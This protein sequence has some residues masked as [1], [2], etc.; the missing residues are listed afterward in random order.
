MQGAR[1]T[2]AVVVAKGP[3]ARDR[4]LNVI[5]GYL[6]G[7][8]KYIPAWETRLGR[9]PQV[10]DYLQKLAA[11]FSVAYRFRDMGRKGI[12]NRIQVISDYFL[13]NLELTS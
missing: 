2:G 10:H 11:V 6:F 4:I 9:S 13:H 12:K 7:T 8:E 5:S 1:D 3:D